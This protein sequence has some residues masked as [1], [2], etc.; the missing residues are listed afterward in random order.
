MRRLTAA[1][2]SASV[3][4]SINLGFSFG[5]EG[6]SPAEPIINRVAFYMS[7]KITETRRA[8]QH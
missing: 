7:R 8:F 1:V 2:A 5:A 6:S 3:M 4:S